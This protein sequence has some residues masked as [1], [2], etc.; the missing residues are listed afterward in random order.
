MMLNSSLS[1]DDLPTPNEQMLII[2]A[3]DILDGCNEVVSGIKPINVLRHVKMENKSTL[4]V[5]FLRHGQ[6]AG[7]AD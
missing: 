3:I 4:H 2:G 6:P 1:T 7:I 5:E